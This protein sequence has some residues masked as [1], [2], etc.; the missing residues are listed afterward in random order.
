MKKR[1][2]AALLALVLCAGLAVPVFAADGAAPAPA[3]KI[4]GPNGFI[5]NQE[6][7]G[8]KLRRLVQ[9]DHALAYEDEPADETLTYTQLPLDTTLVVNDLRQQDGTADWVFVSAWSDPDGDGIY[10]QRLFV[11]EGFSVTV[12]PATRRGPFMDTEGASYLEQAQAIGSDGVGKPGILSSSVSLTTD[13]LYQLFGPDTLLCLEVRRME[14]EG[15]DWVAKE[16]KASWY[17]LPG[18]EEPGL[19]FTD[20][21]DG[22][23]FQVP[24]EWA[25]EEGITNGTSDTTFSPDRDCTEAEI[26]TLL[27]RAAGEPEA[28]GSGSVAN[29]GEDDFFYGA[30]LW[31]SDM[32]MIDPKEFDPGA[33][34]TR[35]RAVTFLWRAAGSPKAE[36]SG[37]SDVPAG[38]DYAAAVDWA[39]EKEVT[40]GVSDTAFDPDGVCS[41]GQIV[42]FL[43]RAYES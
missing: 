1:F 24:V 23:Y 14:K 13:H 27:W 3:V 5:P 19:A 30:A 41:R 35:A 15:G 33:A 38:A 2:L 42:T 12:V 29:V 7:A 8:F 39:V 34:C 26:L 11:S 37:F 28:E 10:E 32:G 16:G 17:L 9:S 18:E 25:V 6:T 4:H 31:A 21:P 43:Y 36:A 40:N 22:A 20:V